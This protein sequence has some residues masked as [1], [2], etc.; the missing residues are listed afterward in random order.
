MPIVTP[1]DANERPQGL[2][3][4]VPGADEDEIPEQREPRR[5]EGDGP[6]RVS[7]CEQSFAVFAHGLPLPAVANFQH[8]EELCVTPG[9]PP[10]E[11]IARHA[12]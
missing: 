7:G 1:G 5:R 4:I 3:E 12:R 6:S 10:Q 2:C 9:A 11:A 8:Q